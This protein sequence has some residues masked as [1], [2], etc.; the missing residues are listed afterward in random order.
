[1]GARQKSNVAY[2]QGSLVLA[3]IAGLV[4]DTWVVFVVALVVLLGANLYMGEIRPGKG[5]HTARS[6]EA[7]LR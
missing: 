5:R 6:D 7:R 2:V 1:M 3:A 4:T